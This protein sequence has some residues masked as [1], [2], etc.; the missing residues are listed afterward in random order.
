MIEVVK[1]QNEISVD[2][3]AEGGIFVAKERS[4]FRILATQKG[5]DDFPYRWIVF[6]DGEVY[7]GNNNS[8]VSVH[9]TLKEATECK[10]KFDYRVYRF[11]SIKEAC[12]WIGDQK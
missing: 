2:S 11:D 1:E 6:E 8:G 10:L 12:K 4:F 5:D 3:L 7:S 9:T